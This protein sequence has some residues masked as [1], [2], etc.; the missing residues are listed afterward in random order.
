LS[1]AQGNKAAKLALARCM[2]IG[3]G[4]PLDYDKALTIIRSM[5]ES[6]YADAQYELAQELIYGCKAPNTFLLKQD[7]KDPTDVEGV[8]WLRR[9][10]ESG[11]LKAHGSLAVCCMNGIGMKKNPEEC[12]KL[13]SFAAMRGDPN[14]QNALGAL[15]AGG[16][17]M[18]PDFKTAYVWFTILKSNPDSGWISESPLRQLRNYL[19]K[20]D[21]TECDARAVA[22]KSQIEKITNGNR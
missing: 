16:I 15:Y 9:A 19:T 8:V 4:L 3:H 6:G 7:T 2:A 11:H 18:D 22:L 5:A 21:I 10:V 12:F 1:A 14:S 20:A 13:A 17:G